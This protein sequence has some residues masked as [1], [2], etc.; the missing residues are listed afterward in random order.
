MNHLM[1]SKSEISILSAATRLITAKH[2]LVA[3]FDDQRDVI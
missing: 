2:A 1:L 3:Q